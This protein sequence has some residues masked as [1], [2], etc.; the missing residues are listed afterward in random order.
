VAGG[1]YRRRTSE[2]ALLPSDILRWLEAALCLQ[3]VSGVLADN[4]GVGGPIH[5]AGTYGA[6]NQQCSEQIPDETTVKH[7]QP[8]M[9]AQ[10]PISRRSKARCRAC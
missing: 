4:V 8:C 6:A 1:G 2:T 9:E 7:S 10:S 3:G 5:E